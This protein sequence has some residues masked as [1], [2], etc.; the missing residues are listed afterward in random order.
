LLQTKL[1][2]EQ[3]L[4]IHKQS[5]L[6]KRENELRNRT[7]EIEE[8]QE[9]I[10]TLRNEIATRSVLL[11]GIEEEF[12]KQQ[13][14]LIEKTRQ[15]EQL[16]SELEQ[17]N[18]QLERQQQELLQKETDIKKI[19]EVSSE[20]QKNI[21]QLQAEIE[22]R[23]RELN[24]YSKDI[25]DLEHE[26]DKHISLFENMKNSIND[27]TKVQTELDPKTKTAGHVDVL[28]EEKKRELETTN[29]LITSK[30]HELNDITKKLDG[31]RLELDVFE[32]EKKK[33][34]MQKIPPVPTEEW[35]EKL[36]IY[37]EIDK[38]L[39]CKD[40]ALQTKKIKEPEEK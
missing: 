36:K 34:E 19:T 29:E 5:E 20:Q 18:T 25:A 1:E 13:T 2:Q 21:T 15:T 35:K 6:D 16:H 7:R 10:E 31:I 23:K 3:Q 22:Q 26:R 24:D 14:R 40:D 33:M 9:M 11:A 17:R 12:T 27:L 30:V 39:N 8:K 32:T 4:F 28:L 38:W 37:N